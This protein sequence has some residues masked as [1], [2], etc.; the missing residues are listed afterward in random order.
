MR[1]LFYKW[2]LLFV[3]LAFG[4]TFA[5]SWH[6][7][8]KE[9]KENA[10]QLLE[11]SLND[12]AE[13]VRREEANLQTIT[14][15]SAASAIAKARAF[16]LL[17]QGDPAILKDAEALKRIRK[18]LDVDELHVSDKNGK[19]I[20]SLGADGHHGKDNY[21]GFN[22]AEET[23][24]R[25]FMQ[26]VTDPAFELV[27]EPQYCGADGRLFQYSGVARLD[28]PGV[29][30]IGYH[31]ERIKKAQQL[32]NVKNIESDMRIG[33]NG[34]LFITGNTQYPADYKR[35]FYTPLGLCQ[36]VACGKYLLTA[37]LPWQEVYHKDR[38]VITTLFVGNTIVFALIFALVAGLLHKVVIKEI[39]AV[40]DSLNEFSKGNFDAKIEV[41]SSSEM[42][43]LAESINKTVNV[44]KKSSLP[45]R[46]ESD[47]EI[48]AMLK[49]SLKPSSIPEN[50]NYKFTAEIF[51]ASEVGSNLCDVFKI[52]KE[53]IAV[54]FAD[55][56][57][58]GVAQGLYMMKARNMLKK[59]LLKNSPEK[60][61]HIVNKELFNNG[62]GN[63]PLNAFLGILHLRSGML[64]IFNAGYVD[65]VIKS[66][67]RKTGFVSSPF[68]SLL[69]GSSD[70]AFI[71][72]PLSLNKGDNIYFYS[73]DIIE[74]SNARGEKYGRE[75]LLDVIS[76]SGNSAAETIRAVRQEVMDFC[77][78]N[79]GDADIAIAVLEY[80]PET[81]EI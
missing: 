62:E 20:A 74:M 12:V 81:A 10:L 9:A 35:V 68:N 44:L 71:P 1:S 7:H 49:N 14:E 24:S 79:P 72:L 6:L 28:E 65:P 13:R 47:A 53:N 75:R 23:Q 50:G 5:L 51:T 26:A 15:M 17:V 78:E 61:L 73:S 22:L 8:R 45:A 42:H 40:T 56:R 43:A 32:A 55:I 76:S 31:P 11:I 4:L 2:L 69:G 58:K 59:A 21:L 27:Q 48:T 54:F 46:A 66:K 80:T 16:A 60:A 39:S 77:G 63:I 64:H 36:S 70:S 3:V 34:K 29:V 30:Q 33:I 57:E 25:I 19:L 18:K 67:N 41:K 37:M 38:T 52:D